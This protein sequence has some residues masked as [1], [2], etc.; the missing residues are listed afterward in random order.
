MNLFLRF[1][2]LKDY[3]CTQKKK[4]FKSKVNVYRNHFL[5]KFKKDA[6]RLTLRF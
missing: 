3:F 1:S 6:L 4:Y 2:A 5:T